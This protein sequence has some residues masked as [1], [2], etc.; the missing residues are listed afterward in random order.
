MK[1][2]WAMFLLIALICIVSTMTV[3][4]KFYSKPC[5]ELPNDDYKELVHSI[6]SLNNHISLII[7]T[8][9][10]LKVVIDTT[11][12]KIVIIQ[13]EYEEDFI[14]ITNQSIGDDIEFFSNYLSESHN[15]FFGNNNPSA[16]KAD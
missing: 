10:S 7:K 15:R 13:K 3:M 6:D 2:Y 9:D 14:D 4:D 11:K 1:Q 8:N 16:I 5:P 12:S